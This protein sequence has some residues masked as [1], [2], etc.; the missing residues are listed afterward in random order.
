VPAH[1]LQM[2]YCTRPPGRYALFAC[3]ANDYLRRVEDMYTVSLKTTLM[4][5]TITMTYIN[6]F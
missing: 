5:H 1:P 2:T 6:G 4:L 3:P